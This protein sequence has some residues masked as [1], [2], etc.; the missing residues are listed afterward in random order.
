MAR[1]SLLR[2]LAFTAPLLSHQPVVGQ[3]PEGT[4]CYSL[5]EQQICI[6]ETNYRDD[7]CAAIA[8]YAR[9]WNLPEGFLARLIWQESRFDPVALSPAAPRVL[10]SSCRRPRACDSCLIRSILPRRWLGPPN[11]CAFSNLNSATSVLRPPLTTEAR[12]GSIDT[13]LVA[14]VR[15][16]LRPALLL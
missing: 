5:S 3:A 8:I 1:L 15:S 2:H 14:G 9:N 13:C 12:A 16:H 10:P 6:S 11:T 7:V 4:S